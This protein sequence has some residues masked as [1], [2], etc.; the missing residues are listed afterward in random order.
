MMI[1]WIGGILVIAACGG[2]GMLIAGEYRRELRD[3]RSL[4]SVLDM[5]SCELSYHLTPLPELCRKSAAFGS[6]G[7]RGALIDL[8]E[9]LNNQV[10]PDV[11]SAMSLVLDN[12]KSLSRRLRRMLERMGNCLGRF[13]LSGQLSGIASVRELCAGELSNLEQNRDQRIR[14][15]QTLGLCAGAALVIIFI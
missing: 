10:Y 1:K 2:T 15:F 6:G 11:C 3:L 13:D 7:V 5:M 9:A 14:S 4:I 8:S 12:R